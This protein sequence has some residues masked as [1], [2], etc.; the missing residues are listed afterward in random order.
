[1]AEGETLMLAREVMARMPDD[2]TDAGESP[3]DWALI[4]QLLIDALPDESIDGTWATHR[5]A[6]HATDPRRR[7]PPLRLVD[8]TTRT[9][10]GPA[11]SRDL[12]AWLLTRVPVAHRL[13]SLLEQHDALLCR[14]YLSYL[15]ALRHVPGPSRRLPPGAVGLLAAAWGCTP[16]TVQASVVRAETFLVAAVH[17]EHMRQIARLRVVVDTATEALEEHSAEELW[18]E[19]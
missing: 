2:D 1:V 15:H 17:A 7:N 10:V 8:M 13:L 19:A 11:M 12:L 6:L 3:A 14:R 4:R 9:A 5:A 18:P 16:R